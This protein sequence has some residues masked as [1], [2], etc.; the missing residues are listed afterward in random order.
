MKV[1]VDDKV[2]EVMAD[3][4]VIDSLRQLNLNPE[5]FLVKRNNEIIHENEKLRENDKL[6]LIKVISGG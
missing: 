2:I 3:S 4:T 6:E 1:T 5:I